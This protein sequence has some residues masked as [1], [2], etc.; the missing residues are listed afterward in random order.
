[1]H[2]FIQANGTAKRMNNFLPTRSTEHVLESE[3]RLKFRAVFKEPW[4]L[5]RD[6]S[7][8][9]YGCD[10]T[11]EA[12]SDNGTSPTNI[13]CAVQLKS[14]AGMAKNG[15]LSRNIKISNVNYM[16]QSSCSFYCL[17][18]QHKGELFYRAAIDI[19]Q[20]ARGRK[21]N[22]P[23]KT[24]SVKFSQR[25]NQE[26]VQQIHTEM[27]EFS[28]FVSSAQEL[29]AND[30]VDEITLE[31]HTS[32]TKQTNFDLVFVYRLDDFGNMI[33]IEHEIWLSYNELARG[34]EVFHRDGQ[35]FDNR[36]G[37]LAIRQ[38]DP[39]KYNVE[40][41]P[42]IGENSAARDVFRVILNGK[43]NKLE[44]EQVPETSQ[45]WDIVR[46]LQKQGISMR[47]VDID[48]YKK[49]CVRLLDMA[50]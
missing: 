9:D 14:T 20:E 18:S 44:M 17:Y 8:P 19:L 37:N 47:Q 13:R 30:D 16:A 26:V 3:S 49:D 39:R 2:H 35:T 10:M 42:T 27:I 41:F 29:I 32:R 36:R 5:V 31:A 1:M 45:F 48:I 22:I 7:T 25:I 24:I 11:I 4:F 15:I 23:R 33:R 46:S 43:P 12:L 28:A 34:F 50:G 6:E 38:I 40:I 21:N